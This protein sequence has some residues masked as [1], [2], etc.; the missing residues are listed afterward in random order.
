MSGTDQ[1][2]PGNAAV[3]IGQARRNGGK[4]EPLIMSIDQT[5]QH[6]AGRYATPDGLP[7]AGAQAECG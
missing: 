2:A 6:S 5:Q 4:P 1:A 3:M 7:G